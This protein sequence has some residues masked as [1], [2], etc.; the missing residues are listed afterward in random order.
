M[1]KRRDLGWK[2]VHEDTLDDLTFVT[3]YIE[4]PSCIA[5]WHIRSALYI[6]ILQALIFTLRPFL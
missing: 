5:A 1:F 3:I 6:K 4:Y 2:S